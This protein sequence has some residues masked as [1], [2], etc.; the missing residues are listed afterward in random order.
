MEVA[1]E[2]AVKRAAE[3]LGWALAQSEAY[4][5]WQRAKKVVQ[6]HEAARIMW[7]DLQRRIEQLQE[8]LTSGKTVTDEQRK[9]VDEMFRL[10]M[11]NPY[12]QELVLAQ[13]RFAEMVLAAQRL[14]HEKAGIQP[15]QEEATQNPAQESTA[16][17]PSS[18]GKQTAV[19]DLTVAKSKLWVPGQP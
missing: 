12:I 18:A 2:P 10:A 16:A 3:A 17:M 11:Y 5:A 13:E 9:S 15:P 4:Q 14:V 6:E 7:D 19:P 8:Q 1:L